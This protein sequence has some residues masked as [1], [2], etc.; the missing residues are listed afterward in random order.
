[1]TAARRADGREEFWRW[2][3][4]RALPEFIP[5]APA[6]TKA[7][8]RGWF[9]SNLFGQMRFNDAE[10]S[11]FVPNKVGGSGAWRSFPTPSLASGITANHE[12]LP[13]ALESLPL[14]WVEL[15]V[16]SDLGALAPYR[17]LRDLGTSGSGGL[18]VYEAL[19]PEVSRWISDGALPQGA[20][21]PNSLH[22]GASRTNGRRDAP[23]SF[24]GSN[25][26]PPPTRR[27]STRSTGVA[28]RLF[29]G[30]TKSA[31]TSRPRWTICNEPSGSS[32]L[33]SIGMD[34]WN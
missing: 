10:V 9:T 25:S 11:I 29:R 20:P 12:Y 2:R 27:C 32:K 26:S 30:R 23:R 1:M 21:T 31:T 5:A 3:R 13:L 8:V 15:S 14:A 4:A 6:V 17:R 16:T 22:A 28:S 19:N 18:D 7:M 34:V 33:S 24:N